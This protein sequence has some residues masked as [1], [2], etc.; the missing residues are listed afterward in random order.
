MNL[1]QR[2]QDGTDRLLT[3]ALAILLVGTSLAFGGAVWWA[4]PVIALMTF[5]FALACLLRIALEG[6]MRLLKSPL[7]LLGVLALGLA[8]VQLVP[9]PPRLAGR[10]SPRSHQAYT[11]GFYPDRVHALDPS[12][13]LPEPA[14]ARSPITVDRSATVRWIAGATVCLVLFW[15]VAHYTDRLRRLYLVWG[16]LL[17]VFF[18]NTGFAVVQLIGHSSGLYG[19]FV[20]GRGPSFAPSPNDLLTA[21]NA[22]LLRTAAGTAPS[23]PA[24]ATLTPDEPFAM[25][26]LM[27][28]PAGYLAMASLGLPLALGLVMQLLAPRGSRERLSVRLGDSGQGGLVFLLVSLLLTATVVAGVLAGPLLSIPFAIGLIVVGFPSTWASG[29]RWT[30]VGMTFLALAGLG[31]GVAVHELQKVLPRSTPPV[32]AESL[33]MAT[34]VWTDA[35]GIARDFPVFGSGLG[36]FASIYPFYKTQDETR[37]TALSTLLQWWVESGFV[38]VALL[39]LGV[40]WCLFRLPGAVRRVGTADRALVFG[41]IG[42]AAGFS[43][44]AAVHWTVELSAV[45]IIASA[46][47]GACN[48]W[49]AGGT[50]LFVERG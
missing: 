50:D 1:R 44:Y 28:G 29:L 39:V 8:L 27:G 17:A 42:A 47:A 41:L 16:C 20:P 34:R 24:W 43:L 46:L 25:G 3:A 40:M 5:V 13:E 6:R 37:T 31:I 2:F 35:L 33:A 38:G 19:L 14:G 23:H 36:S 10:L 32:A 49:L 9:L 22:L 26:T 30:G 4:G 21:P 15:G 48:R 45:A 7:T 11:L 18:L 12:L